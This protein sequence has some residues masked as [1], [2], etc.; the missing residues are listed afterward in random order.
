MT[1]P[2]IHPLAFR[3]SP[4]DFRT[5]CAAIALA[6]ACAGAAAQSY[7]ARPIRL[8]VPNPPGGATDNLARAV[9]PK[10]GEQLGQTIVVD[11][12]PGAAGNLAAEAAV[13]AT[14]DGHTLFLA[15]DGQIVISPH[16]YRKLPF[17]TLKDLTP[18][19]SLVS[20]QMLLAVHPSLPVKS[21]SDFVEYAKRANPPLVYGSIGNGSQHHLA[22][23]ML[24]RRAG[25][26]LLHV[27]Y[28]GGGPALVGL[29]GGEVSVMF[30]GSSA[31]PHVR[32]GK[33]RALALAG[34]RNPAYPG[35]PAMS[36]TYPGLEVNPWLG[37]FAPAGLPAAVLNRLRAEAARM[38]ADPDTQAVIR[39][40]NLD[41]YPTTPK[42]FAALIRADYAKFGE[43]IRSVGVKID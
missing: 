31:G 35:L 12:R 32:S 34:R 6:L 23:E 9:A 25:I 13:K 30:G 16:I 41:P 37:L 33:L 1:K 7:P 38:L 18:V 36:E 43:V 3:L 26:N 14:P 28:K 21:V 17:D 4:P 40:I 15:A 11:N 8:L 24:K 42:E 2:G 39:K 10:L 27:P 20:T 5:G 19:A 22:M 29:F